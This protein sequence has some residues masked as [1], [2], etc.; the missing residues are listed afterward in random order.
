LV[1]SGLQLGS[2]IGNLCSICSINPA[3]QRSSLSRALATTV[4]IAN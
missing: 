3:Q 1:C 2:K 4:P